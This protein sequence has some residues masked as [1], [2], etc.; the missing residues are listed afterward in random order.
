MDLKVSFRKVDVADPHQIVLPGAE[1]DLYKYDVEEEERVEPALYTG[2]VSGED[3]LLQDSTGSTEIILDSGT[4]H[5]VETK[6]PQGYICRPGTDAL[7]VTGLVMTAGSVLAY[8]LLRR[9][10]R[11]LK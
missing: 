7:R 2:L 4:Y 8:V 11:R 10:R 5:L 6:E 3:G 1:F 9:A